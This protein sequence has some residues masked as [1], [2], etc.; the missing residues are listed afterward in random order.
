MALVEQ[1]PEPH[2]FL[3]QPLGSVMTM[4]QVNLDLAE[5]PATELRQPVEDFLVIFL[6]RV[7]EGV[8]RGIPIGI[9]E[10]LH[11]PRISLGPFLD[12]APGILSGRP[13]PIRLKMVAHANHQVPHPVAA[14]RAAQY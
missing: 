10:T 1:I 8:T 2:Q 13:I 12:T 7:K 6:L 9:P 11:R 5:S 3:P 14:S 4:M